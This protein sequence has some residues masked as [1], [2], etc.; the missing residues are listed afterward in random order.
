MTPNYDNEKGTGTSNACFG[1]YWHNNVGPSVVIVYEP[2]P[3]AA[4]QMISVAGQ[5]GPDPQKIL[6]VNNCRTASRLR[7]I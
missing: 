3:V 7:L 6:L 1:R 5:L 4:A 2:V